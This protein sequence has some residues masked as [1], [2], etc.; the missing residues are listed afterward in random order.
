MSDRFSIDAKMEVGR[1]IREPTKRDMRK[2]TGRSTSY[3]QERRRE[4]GFIV[5][6]MQA[7]CTLTSNIC[8][9]YP[10]VRERS[11]CILIYDNHIIHILYVLIHKCK[12]QGAPCVYYKKN[13]II[14]CA[15]IISIKIN[16]KKR[17]KL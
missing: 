11:T 12:V 8:R 5:P 15:Y 2:F 14:I 6:F 17:N 10:L 3:N 13:K 16:M 1:N 4:L 7:V 9:V